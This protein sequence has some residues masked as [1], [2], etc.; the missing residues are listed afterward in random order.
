PN[1]VTIEVSPSFRGR[2]GIGRRAAFRLQYSHGCG[3]S[4]PLDRTNIQ[5]QFSDPAE[6]HQEHPEQ[7][8]DS[9]LAYV[10]PFEMRNP[11][12]RPLSDLDRNRKAY[13]TRG[14]NPF[15]PSI[16]RERN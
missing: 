11:V 1:P 15:R 4:S 14:R 9:V 6:P 2:G 7:C 12:K 3:G 13:D 10:P 8:P 16:S 5:N